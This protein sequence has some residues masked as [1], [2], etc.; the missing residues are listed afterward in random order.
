MKMNSFSKNVC[1]SILVQ[2]VSLSVS[3]ILNL[4]LP[5]FIDEYQYAYWQT[6][7]LYV[8]Y[9]GVLHFGLLDG[10]MLRYSQYDYD[11][12]NKERIR[13]Q[14]K[15]LFGSISIMATGLFLSGLIFFCGTIR[16]IIVLVSAGI[17]TKN[18]VTYN[19]YSF[20]IT[21]RIDKYALFIIVQRVSY[22]LIAIVLLF[23]HINRFEVYC[24]AELFGD[25]FSIIFAQYFNKGM[26]FGKSI[27]WRD[28]FEEW[29]INISS[30]IILMLANWSSMLI[31]SFAKVIVQFRWDALIFGKVSFAFSLSNVFL[32][33]IAAISIVLFPQL[34]RINQIYL[35]QIYR[36]IRNAISPLLF[37]IMSAYY[38][39]C[40]IFDKILPKYSQSFIYLGLLLPVIIYTSKVSLLTNN[41]LKAYR[42][43]REML[44]INITTSILAI[45]FFL[46]SAY[47]INSLNALLISVVISNFIKSV[48]SEQMIVKVIHINFTKEYIFEALITLAFILYASF[49]SR[50][51][52]GIAYVIT[53]IVYLWYI[54][55]DILLIV[56]SILND[57]KK[58]K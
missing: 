52:A 30:G 51:V 43:E 45:L 50:F 57:F 28:A 29:K 40:W 41:Y 7:I 5:Q 24:I 10:I 4:V 47:I 33:F 49:L 39:C 11:Q 18:L 8:G 56:R 58:C 20:Q 26:Y 46:A 38:P 31:I 42:K 25:T 36:N 1:L 19:S 3:F 48:R 27:K 12:I 53:L 35:P 21:N 44:I 9:V 55:N 14:F 34:K 23:L 13:S 6:Y 54:R 15:I 16:N 22:G 2:V 37:I 17:I 32:T